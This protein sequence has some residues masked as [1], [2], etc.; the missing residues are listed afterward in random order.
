MEK[1]NGLSI[2]LAA[3]A[4]L[5]FIIK[6]IRDDKWWTSWLKRLA[7]AKAITSTEPTPLTTPAKR[8]L[9]S[10][11]SIPQSISML[12]L[13]LL[14]ARGVFPGHS[15]AATVQ[16]RASVGLLLITAIQATMASA[17]SSTAIK[18]EYGFQDAE[19]ESLHRITLL[20]L[21]QLQSRA[22]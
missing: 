17:K 9:L 18:M 11:G 19:L 3:I 13:I 16:D 1:I 12:C 5:M 7:T 21:T 22:K 20:A 8:G 14:V 2:A 15:H 4:S 10:G 6:E